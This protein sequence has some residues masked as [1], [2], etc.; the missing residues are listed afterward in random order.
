M[1]ICSNLCF[2]EV[3]RWT[4]V[5][6]I[7]T[8]E[9]GIPYLLFA[10][11]NVKFSATISKPGG[12][13]VEIG[14]ITDYLSWKA[15]VDNNLLSRSPEGIGDKP[16]PTPQLQRVSSC[17]PEVIV[18]QTHGI[19]Y[20]TL[21][22][23]PTNLTDNSYWNDK[24]ANYSLLRLMWMDCNN[25]IHYSGDI[26]DPGYA[27]SL[28]SSGLV[29][30]ETNDESQFYQYNAEFKELCIPSIISVVNINDAFVNDVAT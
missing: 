29:I 10:A 26:S 15:L 28:T 2:V 20:R 4:S 3:P 24:C 8:R 1:A 25:I 30:P 6:N 23:D 18:N 13:T 12:G 7:Q 16:A 19:N 14:A 11:C 22:I 5:C 27:Y 9:G 21:D 17:R